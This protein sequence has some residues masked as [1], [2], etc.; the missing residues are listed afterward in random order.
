MINFEPKE[1]FIENYNKLK[2]AKK[3]ADLYNCSKST[4]L[5]YAKKIG[6]DNKNNQVIKI[7][8]LPPEI[9]IQD[10]EELKSCQKVG[11]KYNC[12]AT[13]VRNYL[14]KIGYTDLKNHNNKLDNV[15]KEDFIND[16]KELKSSQKMAEKYNCSSTAIIQYAHKI[17]YDPNENKVYKLTKQDKKEIIQAYNHIS[18][19]KLAKKYNVSRGMIT[20]LWH[21]NNLVNKHLSDV[22]TTEINIQGQDFGYWHVLYKTEKRNAGG[23]I[24]WHCRCKCGIERDVLG[25]SLR[26]GLSVSCGCLQSK[27]NELIQKLLTEANIPFEREKIFETCVD[28]TYLP[29]DFFV[30][31]QYLIEYDGSQHY[32]KTS[33]FNYDYTHKHD[34]IK[35]KWCKEHNIPLIRI[36]YTHFKNLTLNDLLLNTSNF[37][38]I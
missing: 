35:S 3:M 11:I 1:Q 27:G 34:L 7:A 36:P 25:S 28:K 10:Y 5:N 13:A 32:D 22:D 23:I 37:I 26:Q 14:I 17:N 16:Y 20:K 2:S 33:L 4:I 38:E 15:S 29:F 31:N 30:N 24:Y 9:I 12:S 19:T 21:D 18:S 6:Y 8:D